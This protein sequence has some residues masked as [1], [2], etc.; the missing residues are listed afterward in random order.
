MHLITRCAVAMS[1]LLGCAA[2]VLAQHPSTN[3]AMLLP[4]DPAQW[5]A[6][7]WPVGSGQGEVQ[8]LDPATLQ[9][10]STVAA[11]GDYVENWNFPATLVDY[12]LK[13]PLAIS[14][15]V[16]ALRF[17]LRQTTHVYPYPSVRFLIQDSRGRVFA[18]NTKI[19]RD[20][21]NEA[22]W[23]YG[24]TYNW[25]DG[26]VDRLEPWM[27]MPVEMNNF[28]QGPTGALKLIGVR[29]V[30]GA[31]GK[32]TLLLT[33]VTAVATDVKPMNYWAIGGRF[34]WDGMTTKNAPYL[35]ASDMR[36][37]R[38]EY[39]IRWECLDATG[40]QTLASGQST[41]SNTGSSVLLQDEPRV[42]FPLLPKGTYQ[43]RVMAVSGNAGA[44][45][46][47]EF[48]YYSI[49]TNLSPKATLPAAPGKLI[50]FSTGAGVNVFAKASAAML[51]LSCTADAPQGTT[52]SYSILTQDK[53]QLI[54]ADIAWSGTP[55]KIA[56]TPYLQAHATVKV[57]VDAKQ[58][59]K[60][61]DRSY[62]IFGVRSLDETVSKL[63]P[64]KKRMFEEKIVRNKAD[65]N[66]GGTP[67]NSEFPKISKSFSTWFKEGKEIGYNA[68]ELS[69]PWNE[70]EVL[71]GVYDFSYLDK[72]I[73]QAT[74]NGFQV[75]L[76]VHPL[77]GLT[78][79]WAYADFQQNQFGYAH[80][81][82]GGSSNLIFGPA[83]ER[84]NAGLQ[85]FL[86]R[87]AAHYAGNPGMA[88]YTFTS[89]FF[90]HGYLDQPYL[91]QYVD[92]SDAARDHYITYLRQVKK[93][94]LAS[95]NKA[96]GTKYANWDAVEM[97]KPIF[98]KDANGQLLPRLDAAWKDFMAAK[99][100]A[101]HRYRMGTLNAVRKTDPYCQ[102]GLYSDTEFRLFYGDEVAQKDG[103]IP[104][105]SM[106]EQFP[107]SPYPYRVRYEPHAKVA[108][109]KETVDIG[110][111]N[112]LF[113]QPG[114]DA[115]HNYWFPEWTMQNVTPEIRDGELR[116]KSWFKV[117]DILQGVKPVAVA[118]SAKPMLIYSLD[119]LTNE[120]QHLFTGR[121]EDYRRPISFE[122]SKQ[123]LDVNIVSNKSLTDA[124]LKNIPY[125]VV[126]YNADI[127]TA[128]QRQ[129]L[130][131]YVQQGGKII[132]EASAGR[133][134]SVD[135]TAKDALLRDLRLPAIAAVAPASA[136]TDIT[137][138]VAPGQTPLSGV[139]DVM[140]RVKEWNPPIN[141][142]PSPWIQNIN[143][144]YLAVYRPAKG[145]YR[146]LAAFTDGAP[147][148]T[149]HAVGKGS[150][151]VFWGVVD[152]FASESLLPQL[153]RWAN[154]TVGT[155]KQ[156][157][158]ELLV[159]TYVKGSQYFMLGRRFVEHD[160]ISELKQ[161]GGIERIKQLGAKTLAVKAP[162]LPAGTYQVRDILNEKDYP[163]MDAATLH[164]KGI[165]LSLFKAD[166]FVLQFTKQ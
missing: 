110:V 138:T 23:C 35:L 48:P 38:G 42:E 90:D 8:A 4:T 124:G 21:S 106:E 101:I 151:L 132:M 166:A 64:E 73:K 84:Y 120:W 135:A 37:A 87:L 60:V 121:V 82:W 165:E 20:V 93:Y 57:I 92:Y 33:G 63:Y 44:S 111:S 142:Q 115:L 67:V 122:I 31:V 53:Q 5:G 160:I 129:A 140:F 102:V 88:G 98:A 46:D 39:T 3:S 54:A 59:G 71:P 149:L 56:L 143:K 74:D 95:L 81:L 119:T 80:G 136:Q 50:T 30:L 153:D 77:A 131:R 130:L 66:E 137:A 161:G 158:P 144:S 163:A 113:Y 28:Y 145:D 13:T 155:E 100:D 159:N 114:R 19:V 61:L 154:T 85:A 40:W 69:A 141:G 123:Q 150:V 1:L 146:T 118:K 164:T 16:S 55:V 105:G 2:A 68:V 62:R 162:V 109:T 156:A 34:G 148:A 14:Q 134:D 22:G 36:L 51:T 99:L 126:P 97:P 9:L 96:Y 94:S 65:W 58:G 49:R 12:P 78:P 29:C 104:Q 103:F 7:T 72:L 139:S 125:V 157:D 27:V 127:L 47:M 117:C 18:V 112:M 76:R 45:K 52:L 128:A 43:L 133:Y 116:L 32:T 79:L 25:T 107:P 6:P 152:W 41:V 15:N 24:Q 70:I 75:L 147:A 91:N 26:E 86:Q 83:S 17:W 108:K 11:L 10:A 89:L